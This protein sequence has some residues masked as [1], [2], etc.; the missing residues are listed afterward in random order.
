M[1]DEE[2]YFKD[3]KSGWTKFDPS[4]SPL[5]ERINKIS[6]GITKIIEEDSKRTRETIERLK[7]V[8]EKRNS[9][10]TNT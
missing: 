6:L 7:N 1:I 4:N 2:E 3:K 8:L 10:N 5:S 9:R